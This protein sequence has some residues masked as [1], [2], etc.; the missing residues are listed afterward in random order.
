MSKEQIR[1]FKYRY[2]TQP[3]DFWN[4]ATVAPQNIEESVIAQMPDEVVSKVYQLFI[5][6]PP[7]LIPIYLCKGENN[8][9]TY[10]FS[11]YALKEALGYF[12]DDELEEW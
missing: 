8:G 4:G 7:E 9:T 2:W 1:H 12:V 3:I 6:S 11:D 5:P 10:I